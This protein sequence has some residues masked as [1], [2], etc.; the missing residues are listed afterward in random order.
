MMIYEWRKKLVRGGPPVLSS[1]KPEGAQ[2]RSV[3]AFPTTT[4][5]IIQRQQ[6]MKNL[7]GKMVASDTL[8]IDVDDSTHVDTCRDILLQLGIGFQE[9]T[10]GNRGCHFEIP[11][12]PM[13]G[14]NVIYSQIQWL[15]S[16]GLWDM[17]DTSI[18]KPAGQFRCIGAK[19]RKTGQFKRLVQE[20][21]GPKILEITTLSPPPV[22]VKNDWLCEEGTPES[23][24]DFF[25]NVLAERGEGKRHPHMYITFQAGKA[26]GLER[27]E[28]EDCIRWWN[29][30]MTYVP[31]TDQ[32]IEKKLRS[33]K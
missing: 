6:S 17:I 8:L 4:V 20:Y 25:M 21:K 23:E 7:N 19:H 11:I 12:I 9:Y 15:K 13:M 1:T 31:H 29:Q 2:F 32:A 22:V 27:A 30:H 16:V 5:S 10:T 33:F 26:A 18:Y 3:Y 24:F 14:V 28:I